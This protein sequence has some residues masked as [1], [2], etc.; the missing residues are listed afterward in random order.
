MSEE[1]FIAY[2]AFCIAAYADDMAANFDL[3]LEKARQVATDQLSGRLPHGINTEGN[4]FYCIERESDAGQALIGYLWF[5][6]NREEGFAW[7]EAIDLFAPFQ[8]QG[9]GSEVLA[10]AEALLS[11]QGIRSTSLH[12]FGTNQRALRFYQRQGYKITG[13]NMKKKW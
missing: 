9:H 2:A 10:L 12:V 4:H 3:P 11:A 5:S 13:Y 7:L 8:N 6:I 1:G